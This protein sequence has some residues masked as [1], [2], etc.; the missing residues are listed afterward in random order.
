MRGDFHQGLTQGRCEAYVCI[1]LDNNAS[2]VRQ[3]D[4]GAVIV[5]T[6]GT[7]TTRETGQ[8]DFGGIH[9]PAASIR[10]GTSTL[11]PQHPK[12]HPVSGIF[13]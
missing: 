12:G 1:A 11:T 10:G 9:T 6:D 7:E 2:A 3:V 5:I 13:P 8:A 4:I